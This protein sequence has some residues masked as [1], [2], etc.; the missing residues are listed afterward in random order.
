MRKNKK[1]FLVLFK[2]I[3]IHLLLIGLVSNSSAQ[4]CKPIPSFETD[5]LLFSG[6]PVQFINNSKASPKAS[7]SWDFNNDGAYDSFTY[8]PKFTFTKPGNYTINLLVNDFSCDTAYEESFS[9]TIS[10]VFPTVLPK[11]G[12]LVPTTFISV[13][14]ELRIIDNSE[15]KPNKWQWSISPSKIEGLPTYHFAKGYSDK[16]QNPIIV[17]ELEGQYDITLK[18]SNDLGGG[19]SFTIPKVVTALN[20]FL[21]NSPIPDTLISKRGFICDDGGKLKNY[22]SNRN[23]KMLVQP[24]C[25]DKLYLTFVDFDIQTGDYLKIFDGVNNSGIPLHDSFGF[26][27]GFQNKSG[28]KNLWLPEIIEAKSGS[29]YLE[30][31][32]DGSGNGAGFTIRY[33]TQKPNI[34]KPEAEISGPDSIYIKRVETFYSLNLGETDLHFWD[35]DGNGVSDIFTANAI[36][37]SYNKDTQLTIR[38]VV[39][40]CGGNDTLLKTVHII[41]PTNWP[42]CDF[43]PKFTKASVG[44]LIPINDLSHNG[45]YMWKWSVT[46][47]SGG[48]QAQFI[49]SSQSKQN[50][51]LKFN[52]TGWYSVKLVAT[53][54]LG[55]DSVIKMNSVYIYPRCSVAVKNLNPDQAISSFTL[56]EKGN[57]IRLNR[58]SDVGVSSYSDFSAENTPDIYQR[59]RYN[60][61]FQRNSIFKKVDAAAWIDFNQDGDFNDPGESVFN[62]SKIGD[63]SWG[64]SITIPSNC[65]TGLTHLRIGVIMN[66]DTFHSCGLNNSGEFED[67]SINI[68][69]DPIKPSITLKGEDPMVLEEFTYYTEPGYSALDNV[70]GD[71]TSK[72]SVNNT[73]LFNK[74]GIYLATYTVNDK[75]GNTAVRHRTIEVI[76]DTTKPKLI[77]NGLS[78]QYIEVYKPYMET[79]AFAK[80]NVDGNLDN[81]ILKSGKV[82]SSHLGKYTLLYKVSDKRGNTSIQKREVT[83]GDTTKPTIKLYGKTTETIPLG[84][85]YDDFGAQGWDNYTVIVKIEKTGFIDSSKPGTY[86]LSYT[87]VDSIGNRSMSLTR[88]IIVKDFIKPKISLSSYNMTI[89]VNTPFTPP[90]VT[91]TDNYDKFPS[92]YTEPRIIETNKVETFLIDFIAKD[93]SGNSS[94]PATLTLVVYDTIRPEIELYGGQYVILNRWE[95][96]EEPGFT[97]SDNYD[98]QLKIAITGNFVNSDFPGDYERHYSVRDISGNSDSITRYIHV[99]ESRSWITHFENNIDFNVYPQPANN[100]VCINSEVAI[101]NLELK[102]LQ[103]KILQSYSNETG[104]KSIRINT[105]D[106][107][108]GLYFANFTLESRVYNIRISIAR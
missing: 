28:A 14:E 54:D 46:S 9:K 22:T 13:N 5:T 106:F 74:T 77:L 44:D 40:N 10:V 51:I 103:G 48:K 57:N 105:Q 78:T 61:L 89:E 34:A 43:K 17:F 83:V 62:R 59:Q 104:S 56:T 36:S 98:A 69:K 102:N 66:G 37:K 80:D 26:P 7:Y 86:T 41:K 35:M 33:Y 71:L 19:N 87:A 84:T 47:Q 88:T 70:D 23:F 85:S 65:K 60:L 55:T 64:D 29:V 53:N 30:W 93:N 25:A 58:T 100:F 94:L 32:T 2:C 90:M 107:P 96:Y 63:L 52:D 42:V 1:F 50:P 72:V 8:Q 16:S 75:A 31:V 73:F 76:Q 20:T 49:N 101:Q 12:F 82:D 45:P 91:V 21:F 15:F 99:N 79:G 11:S 95:P 27:K 18:A 3:A 92:Y 38:Y 108:Q 81:F 97:A 67:Y 68:I 24:T 4:S 39:Q 6:S